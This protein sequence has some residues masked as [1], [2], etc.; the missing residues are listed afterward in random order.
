MTLLCLCATCYG[1]KVLIKRERGEKKFERIQTMAAQLSGGK[2]EIRS[3]LNGFGSQPTCSYLMFAVS[4]FLN[5]K[6]HLK[7]F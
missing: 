1:V 3:R 4:I 7:T 2:F 5:I 6:T